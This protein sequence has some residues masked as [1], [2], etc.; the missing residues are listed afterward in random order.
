M[1]KL[2]F[3]LREWAADHSGL[4]YPK[5]RLR[6]AVVEPIREFRF[7][8]FAIVMKSLML[9]AI[10]FLVAIPLLYL[11][12]LLIYTFFVLIRA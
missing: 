11:C 4:Q 7:S 5:P 12:G 9:A 3:R 1:R 10:C 6:P 8:D 2:L